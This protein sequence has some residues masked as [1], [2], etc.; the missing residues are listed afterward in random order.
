[1]S[2]P[3]YTEAKT[4]SNLFAAWRHVR[5][6]AASSTHPEISDAASAFEAESHKKLLSIQ[7]RLSRNKYEF[8]SAK[9][10]LKDKQKRRQEGKEPR[11]IVVATLESRVVQR[12]IL[13]VVQ[14]RRNSKLYKRLNRLKDVLE[15][16]YSLGGNPDGG[17]PKAIE[18]VTGALREG[19]V[20]F[21]KSDIRSFFTAIPHQ[22]IVDF[23]REQ[24]NDEKITKL[25]ARGLEIEIENKEELGEYFHLF[26]S[27]GVGV[28]QGSSLSALSG[29]ILLN[30]FDTKMNQMG[31]IRC[32]RYIDDLIIL[33][34]TNEIVQNW[35][36]R[37]ET[38]LKKFKMRLYDPA[39]TPAK[40]QIGH[41]RDG[42]TYLGCALRGT[43]VSPAAASRS[44][45]LAKIDERI[46][47]AKRLILSYRA[48]ESGRTGKA[49]VQT[50]ADIDRVTFGWGQSYSFVYNRLIFQPDGQ[51]N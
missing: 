4:L 11:P 21:F 47:D 15:C 44:R 50:L 41:S 29:N 18:A 2:D 38:L 23:V 5:K 36:A 3:F 40:A 24:T 25:F 13:Q 34:K 26:P 35:R 17:V 16:P 7:R 8:P 28:P 37:A 49:F 39:Q 10:V 20:I 1:V 45:L 48:N 9:G 14:P 6:S 12:A 33:G 27:G 22:P 32:F 46:V 51:R 19:Y 42:F 30:D 43:Q 31:D